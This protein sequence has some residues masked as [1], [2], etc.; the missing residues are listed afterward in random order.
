MRT[1]ARETLFKIL[2][3]S[4]FSDSVDENLK[5]AMYKNEQ[6]DK[7]DRAYCDKV[8]SL[9][10]EHGDEFTQLLDKHS[11]SFPENRI[12]PADKSILLISLAEILYCDDIPDKVSVN[13]A[14]NIASKYS[15]AKSASFITGVLSGVIGE[16]GNV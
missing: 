14:A 13:E 15:S 7:N 6:L 9:I 11:I 4:L 16:K 5:L 1:I 8:L 10:V 12:Y 3:S 2:F